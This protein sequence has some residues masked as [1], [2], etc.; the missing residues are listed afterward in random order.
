MRNGDRC[1]ALDGCNG[2]LKYW[3]T[4]WMKRPIYKCKRCR[5]FWEFSDHAVVQVRPQ[6]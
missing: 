1:P 3:I 5:R 4:L 2:E 6:E